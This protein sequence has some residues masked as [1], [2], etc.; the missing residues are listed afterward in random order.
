[1]LQ[2]TRLLHYDPEIGH[3]YTLSVQLQQKV[4]SQEKPY[5]CKSCNKQYKTKGSLTLLYCNRYHKYVKEIKSLLRG[6]A[7]SEGHVEHKATTA[8][9]E[10]A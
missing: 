6:I 5:V 2:H 9:Q 8:G 4:H 7:D 1:M 3:F 10:H